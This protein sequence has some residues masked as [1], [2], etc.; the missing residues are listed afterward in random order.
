M[1]TIAT[2]DDMRRHLNLSANDTA[3]DDDL[4]QRLQTASQ[5][6]E[7]LTQRRYCPRLKTRDIPLDRAGQRELIL[8]DDLLELRALSIGGVVQNLAD[9]RLLP[10]D[11]DAP[12]SV[13]QVVENATAGFADDYASNVSIEGVWGWHDRWSEAWRASGEALRGAGLDARADAIAVNDAAGS[14]QDGRGPRFQVGQL[15][16]IDDEYLR[17]T[18]IDNEN[19]RLFVLRGVQGTAAAAHR[20]G[21]SIDAYTPALAIRDLTLRFAELMSK[22]AGPLASESTPLLERMRRVT[23]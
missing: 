5:L 7:S 1:Y 23:A 12:A 19:N 14:D 21:A 9:Y 16:R 17:V 2:L 10:D 22:S 3:E 13:L 4:L 20:P 15:L 11:R 8:P 18:A 6:I